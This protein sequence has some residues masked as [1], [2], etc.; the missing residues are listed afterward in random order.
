[1]PKVYRTAL[2]K[3]IDIETLRLT[4]EN[5]VAVGNQRVNARGDELDHKGNVVKTKDQQMADHYRKKGYNVP[6]DDPV[7]TSKRHVIDTNAAQADD[8]NS[9]KLQD[10]INRLTQQLAEKE[11]LIGSLKQENSDKKSVSGL[12][13][14]EIDQ[15]IKTFKTEE[16][17]QPVVMQPETSE[18]TT[19]LRGGLANAIQKDLEYKERTGATTKRRRI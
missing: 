2:G 12:P 16:I 3:Q 14:D 17:D 8:I 5:V 9:E 11:Q 19:P 18:N 10:V 4:N 7:Y 6:T 13:G 15:F 1:M